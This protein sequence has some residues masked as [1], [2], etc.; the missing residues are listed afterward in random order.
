M[1]PEEEYKKDSEI[2]KNI[3]VS[4]FRSVGRWTGSG[5]DGPAQVDLKVHSH[6]NLPTSTSKF[7]LQLCFSSIQVPSLNIQ[8]G[9]FTIYFN[10]KLKTD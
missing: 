3:E 2:V 5:S 6:V 9:R 4:S 1:G 10:G 8:I 7:Q